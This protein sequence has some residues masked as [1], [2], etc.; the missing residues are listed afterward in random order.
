MQ[1]GLVLSPK[2]NKTFMLVTHMM[3][4]YGFRKPEYDVQLL[5]LD[6]CAAFLW[7]F[8]EQSVVIKKGSHMGLEW[9]EGE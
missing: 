7:N 6:Y 8:M 2:K 3:V 5:L 9:H 4:P 1:I